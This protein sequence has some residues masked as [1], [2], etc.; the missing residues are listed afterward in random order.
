MLLTHEG[1][2]GGYCGSI[3][4]RAERVSVAAKT[5]RCRVSSVACAAV[6]CR[7]PLASCCHPLFCL[8][9]V[10]AAA[11]IAIQRLPLLF[12]ANKMDDDDAQSAVEL[13]GLLGLAEIDNKPWHIWQ[14]RCVA[15]AR[16]P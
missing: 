2:C 8:S 16:G 9:R 13:V 15:G 10:A 1:K 7:R 12:F 3:R 11:D 4:A 6:T 14:G 5:L